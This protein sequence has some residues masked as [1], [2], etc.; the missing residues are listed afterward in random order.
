MPRTQVKRHELCHS[1]APRDNK[2]AGYSRS[3][4]RL[5]AW[6][7]TEVNVVGE[8]I[9]YVRSAKSSRRQ[10]YSVNHYKRDSFPNWTLVAIGTVHTNCRRDSVISVNL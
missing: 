5:E 2:V 1:T 3:F 6:V 7:C 8:K 9:F 10:G 4:K